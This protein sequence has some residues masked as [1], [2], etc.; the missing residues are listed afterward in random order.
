MAEID[1]L[2]MKVIILDDIK[3]TKNKQN[4]EDYNRNNRSE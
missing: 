4:T 2:E 3:V 1:T